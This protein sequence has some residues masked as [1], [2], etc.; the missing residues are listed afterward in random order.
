MYR[1]LF[2]DAVGGDSGLF[3]CDRLRLGGCWSSSEVDSSIESTV[4]SPVD[5]DIALVADRYRLYSWK[6]SQA[7]TTIFI[8]EC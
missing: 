5:A 4:L 1:R 8:L 6:G 2:V 7:L 3:A